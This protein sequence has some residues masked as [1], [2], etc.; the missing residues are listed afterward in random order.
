MG[1]PGIA[2]EILGKARAGDI[3][4][5]FAD[6]SKARALLGF[7]PAH[8]LEDSLDELA[9]WIGASEAADHGERARRQLEARG[10]VS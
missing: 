10:L 8:P 5:C 7:E 9:Q 6:I 4:H 2:P 3:R 1:V